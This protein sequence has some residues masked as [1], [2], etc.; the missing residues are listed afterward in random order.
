VVLGFGV[1]VSVVVTRVVDD[2]SGV[3]V[4]AV[5]TIG[6]VEDDFD[7]VFEV[8]DVVVV[9]VSDGAARLP[10]AVVHL[11]GYIDVQKA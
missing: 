5:L 6:V 11:T 9:V 4:F 3:V 7:V 8:T 10:T 1:V 2:N